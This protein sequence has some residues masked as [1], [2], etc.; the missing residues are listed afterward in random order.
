MEVQEAPQQESDWD[1]EALLPRIL[2]RYASSIPHDKETH[3]K[4]VLLLSFISVTQQGKSLVKAVGRSL[5]RQAFSLSV[6]SRIADPAA[7]LEIKFDY[8][9]GLQHTLGQQRISPDYLSQLL[10]RVPQ[11]RQVLKEIVGNVVGLATV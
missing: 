9:V 6:D 11:M 3:N 1:E 10:D 7:P 8:I 5:L 4:V 2:R